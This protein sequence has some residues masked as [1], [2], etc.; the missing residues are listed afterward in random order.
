MLGAM[1]A[2]IDLAVAAKGLVDPTAFLRSLPP[3]GSPGLEAIRVYIAHDFPWPGAEASDEGSLELCQ[4]PKDC[5]LP[6]FWAAAVLRGRSPYVAVLDISCPPRPEWWHRAQLEIER[7]TPAFFGAVEPGWG[8][9]DSRI[10]GYL[11]E[12][13]QFAQPLPQWLNE[14][15][16]NNA[17]FRRELLP[18]AEQLRKKGF[19]KTSL[20]WGLARERDLRFEPVEGLAVTYQKGFNTW[21]YVLRRYRHGRCFAGTRH[22][23]PGQLPR[24]LCLLGTPALPALRLARIMRACRRRADLRRA[25]RLHIG[26]VIASEL[27]WSAGEFA[28]YAIGAGRACE[29]LE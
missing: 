21:P 14:V 25:L 2:A 11:A 7:G 1:H 18:T 5:P 3:P 6:A 17:V 22:W 26:P 16:G 10:A 20:V 27:G 4:M 29:Y 13:S 15:P 12:Y 24:W 28:G 23:H 8:E 9:C 19:S